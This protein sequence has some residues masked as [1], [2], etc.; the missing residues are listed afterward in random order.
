MNKLLLLLLLSCC[1]Y[2]QDKEEQLY[3]EE[4]VLFHNSDIK[5]TGTLTIPKSTGPHPAVILVTGSGAQNRDEEI[6]GFKIFAQIANHLASNGIAVLRYDD[7]GI[8]GS[9]GNIANTIA[10]E[11]AMDVISGIELLK[12]RK[13]I[14]ANK[15]G[16]LGHSEG[17]TVAIIV[18]AKINVA[19]IV[20]MAG[21]TVSGHDLLLEQSRLI[22]LSQ[23]ATEEQTATSSK[24]QKTLLG[25]I[26]DKETTEQLEKKLESIILDS[27]QKLPAI[28]Q[29]QVGNLNNYASMMAKNI[30][31]GADNRWFRN[32][33][34]YNPAN[35][36]SKVKC[37]VLALFG[38][39]DIQVPFESNSKSLV[40][41]LNKGG[42][43]NYKIKIFQ[44][45]N[46]LFQKAKTGAIN[47]YAT[48][49]KEFLPE[50]LTFIS[51][52]LKKQVE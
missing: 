20:L 40:A 41:A 52:W 46:H 30:L 34:T 47:E 48:L 45:A 49:D 23:G 8:G 3:A 43:S 25:G 42:N 18:A 51:E 28:Q 22:M 38:D 39:L 11:S 37:G 29:K 13:D 21:C 15:I 9:T 10:Q 16:V 33:V 36:L 6:L 14:I 27:L 12:K 24:I 35:D 1:V 31:K 19:F 44:N 4:D 17:G 5:L 32:F 2:S 26:R 7:R 50:F